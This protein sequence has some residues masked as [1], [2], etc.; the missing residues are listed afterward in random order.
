MGLAFMTGRLIGHRIRPVVIR[1]HSSPV[2]WIDR[3][4]F[5]EPT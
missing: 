5:F 4:E 3:S 1:A 2:P